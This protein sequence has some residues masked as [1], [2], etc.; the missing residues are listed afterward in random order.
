[1]V[2][3]FLSTT[4]CGEAFQGLGIQDVESLILVG[5]LFLLV[6]GRR[7]ERKKKE[8][9]KKIAMVKEGFLWARP[10]LLAVQQVAVV[11]CN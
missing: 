3:N 8:K 1:M 7:R 2:P 10:A 6:G 5:A 4:W 9:R 11:R